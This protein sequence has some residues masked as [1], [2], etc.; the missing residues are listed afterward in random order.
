MSYLP[1]VKNII[2]ES[3]INKKLFRGVQG[4]PWHGG[5]IRGGSFKF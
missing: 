5:P 4:A 2:N 1:G 3:K